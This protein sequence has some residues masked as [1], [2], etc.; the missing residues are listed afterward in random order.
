MPL[1]ER[2]LWGDQDKVQIAIDRLRTFEP[3]DGY[4]LAFSGGK[5]SCVIKALADMAGVHYDAHY[6]LTTVDPPELVRFIRAA[7]RRPPVA[8]EDSEHRF[9]KK[10]RAASSR[11]P[12]T[13]TNP[14][15]V[16]RLNLGHGH[17]DT[18]GH[19]HGDQPRPCPTA[20][21]RSRRN[22]PPPSPPSS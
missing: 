4:Y 21:P 13:A 1:I 11:P 10:F 16:H 17:A 5:D 7:L 18:L 8:F 2:T 6:S 15:H 14:G 9:P 20:L 22:A 19:V 12:S 3:P